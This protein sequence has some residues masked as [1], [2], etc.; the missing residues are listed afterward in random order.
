MYM[1][2]YCT[3]FPV[4]AVAVAATA[5]FCLA[6]IPVLPTFPAI[7][8]MAMVAFVLCQASTIMA[9]ACMPEI[10]A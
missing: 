7:L 4:A 6:L 10:F 5:L 1:G 2:R 8:G 9:K 3:F